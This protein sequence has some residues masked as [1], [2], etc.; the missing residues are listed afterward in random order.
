MESLASGP[1]FSAIKLMQKDAFIITNLP[2]AR[3]WSN[4]GIS[5]PVVWQTSPIQVAMLLAA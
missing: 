5:R 3:N 2:A 4:G 1:D